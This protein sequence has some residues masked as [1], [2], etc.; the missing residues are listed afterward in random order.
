M[1]ETTTRYRDGQ[2][3]NPFEANPSAEYDSGRRFQNGYR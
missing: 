2:L 3:I 1:P